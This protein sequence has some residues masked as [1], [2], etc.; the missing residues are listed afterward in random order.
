MARGWSQEEFAV[1]VGV[2][3]KYI[4]RIEAGRENLSIGSI[5]KLANALDVA[6]PALFTAPTTPAP[7]PGRPAGRKKSERS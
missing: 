5:T 7:R 3:S 1:K 4:Q 2:S 6:V